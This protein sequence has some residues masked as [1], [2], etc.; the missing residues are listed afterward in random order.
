VFDVKDQKE[1]WG[2]RNHFRT[3]HGGA[4]H[5]E[6]LVV[7]SR[8]S[9]EICTLDLKG[10]IEQRFLILK[11]AMPCDIDFFGDYALVGCLSGPGAKEAEYPGAPCYIYHWPTKKVV[12]VLT[13]KKDFDHKNGRHIHNAAWW[14]QVVDGKVQ[15][16]FI[17]LSYWNPGDFKLVEVTGLPL[18]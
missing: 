18:D 15:K 8:G 13:P 17:A 1:V 7:C 9:G 4:F 11:G 6:K 10:E 12:S 14:P 16:L 2:G 5:R 3:S